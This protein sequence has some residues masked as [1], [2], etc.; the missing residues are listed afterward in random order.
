MKP[1]PIDA[2]EPDRLAA[3]RRYDILDTPAEAEFDDFTA[4]AAHI[5][6]TPTAL[7]SLVD[8]ER[9]WFKSRVGLDASETPR[10]ISFCGH[11]IARHEL[12]E[13]PDTLADE[14]FSDNPLVTGAPDIRFYAGTPLVTPEGFALGTLCVI[15][16]VPRRLAKAQ[17]DALESLGRQVVR[18][19]EFRMLSRRQLA[20]IRE[21]DMSL[22]ALEAAKA[23]AQAERERAE[24]ASHAKSEFLAAMSHEIRTPMN[25]VL[26]MTELLAAT[27]LDDEQRRYV[28]VI[29]HSG[30][31]LLEIIDTILDFSRVEAGKVDVRPV[32]FDAAELVRHTVEL[33]QGPAVA[34]GVDLHCALDAPAG[35]RVIGDKLLISRVLSNLVSN[36]VKFTRGGAVTVSLQISEQPDAHPTAVFSVR[37]TG[38]GIAR[39]DLQRLFRPFEQVDSGAARRYGGTGPGLAL[40]KR[41]VELMGGALSVESAPGAGSHFHF[42]LTLPRAPAAA[43]RSATPPPKRRLR[44]R[45]LLVEDNKVNQMVVKAMLEKLGVTVNVAQNGRQA[46]DCWRTGEWDAILMDCQMPEMD[47]YQATREIRQREGAAERM[48]IIALTANA[49]SGDAY[50]CFVAGMD[51]FVGKPVS[52][53]ALLRALGRY[54]PAESGECAPSGARLPLVDTARSAEAVAGF[55]RAAVHLARALRTEVHTEDAEAVARIARE[56]EGASRAAGA[57]QLAALCAEYE[58]LAQAAALAVARAGLVELDAMLRATLA[59]F[60]RP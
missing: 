35:C 16:Q 48:P 45:V 15:D 18:Q 31:S 46:V 37:D 58:A 11:A 28:E 54:L 29:R 49:M 3:L 60:E 1:A 20:T 17:R 27:A 41:V 13:V 6:G 47:G 32:N 5:C 42:A 7:I 34:H 10:D 52:Q 56:L 55:R 43:L 19:L 50:T 23:Q 30:E 33:F 4:L 25:G 44:G 40:S 59:A 8:A 36:A 9:Q 12:F 24:R 53:T 38:I 26:G 21:R 22:A 51:G 39:E 14:R 2:N 57:L